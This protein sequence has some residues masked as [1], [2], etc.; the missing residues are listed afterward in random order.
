MPLLPLPH[1]LTAS[2]VPPRRQSIIPFD[3][4]RTSFVRFSHEMHLFFVVIALSSPIS[5]LFATD[6]AAIDRPASSS[7]RPILDERLKS[8]GQENDTS[9]PDLTSDPAV[10]N[11]TDSPP[12]PTTHRWEVADCSISVEE[13]DYWDEEDELLMQKAVEKSSKSLSFGLL[14]F[15]F[16]IVC[17]L[18][19]TLFRLIVTCRPIDYQMVPL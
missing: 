3:H 10:F 5:L 7:P 17:V 8:T 18:L 9:T 6:E 16:T 13:D 12:E 15:T 19:V 4:L 2:F 14:L 11:S 1:A